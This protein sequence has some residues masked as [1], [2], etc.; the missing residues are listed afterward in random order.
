[1]EI[2]KEFAEKQKLLHKTEYETWSRICKR[3]EEEPEKKLSKKEKQRVE[4][5]KLR[6]TFN[7][8]KRRTTN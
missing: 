5:D 7:R 1:M 6:L 8:N 3:F 4:M 2:S